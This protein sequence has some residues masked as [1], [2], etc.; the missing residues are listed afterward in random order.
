[1]RQPHISPTHRVRGIARR[2]VL[3]ALL[4]PATAKAA[5]FRHQGHA[6]TEGPF[7]GPL[8][9]CLAPPFSPH[10]ASLIQEYYLSLAASR[11]CPPGLTKTGTSCLPAGSQFPWEVG[12]PLPSE[13]P[14]D[15][16][17]PDL[18]A[19]LYPP[20]DCEYVR[21]GGDILVITKGLRIVCAGIPALIR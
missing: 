1:M 13:A 2:A 8:D 15:A 3:M 7:Y 6:G 11:R 20:Y 21:V 10:D 16:L 4:L 5:N 18:M 17:P 12:K 14:T 19:Q 9:E